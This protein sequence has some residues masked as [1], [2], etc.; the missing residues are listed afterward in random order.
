MYPYEDK[1]YEYHMD[2]QYEEFVRW[3][4]W[5][6]D[7]VFARGWIRVHLDKTDSYQ[8]A[9]LWIKDNCVCNY[10]YGWDGD[11]IFESEKEAALFSLRWA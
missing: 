6:D 9:E 5:T 4:E 3:Q 11:F 10:E 2:Q 7:L 8:D 1:W